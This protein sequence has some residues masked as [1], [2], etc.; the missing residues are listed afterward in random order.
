MVTTSFPFVANSG[1]TSATFAAGS[2]I[3]SCRVWAAQGGF[4]SP[5]LRVALEDY[6]DDTTREIAADLLRADNPRFDM[7][8]LMPTSLGAT[9]GDG[10]WR[11]MQDHLADPA[12]VGQILAE[13]ET[14]A[15]AAY[16]KR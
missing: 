10:F 16:R 12:R 14:E 1:M 6:P 8:D 11:A 3:N 4:I 15:E 5:N 13:L 2:S 9:R 7:S